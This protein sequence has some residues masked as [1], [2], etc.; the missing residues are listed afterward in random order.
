ME[1]SEAIPELA[2]QDRVSTSI[3]C[4]NIS[5]KHGNHVMGYS[6]LVKDIG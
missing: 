2:A 4:D 1:I 6:I 5:G 3:T